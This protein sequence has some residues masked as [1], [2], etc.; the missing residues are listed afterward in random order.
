MLVDEAK[1]IGCGN[2]LDYCPMNA[3]ALEGDV[4]T[5]DQAECVECSACLRAECCPTNALYRPPLSYPRDLAWFFSDPESTHPTT[6]IPGRGTEEMKTNEITGRFP[7][8][9]A[10]IAIELGRPGTG[11]R[12]REVEKVARAVARFGV[13]FEPQNPVTALMTDKKAGLLPAELQ[14]LKVLSAIVEFGVE[15]SRVPAI[16]EDLKEIAPSLKTVFSLDLAVRC[17]ED[18]SSPVDKM[19]LPFPLSINGKTNTGLGRAAAT[20]KKQ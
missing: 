7:M 10:G 12:F 5:V 3:I 20:G 17:E 13:E 16:L 1:C 14:D 9:Y 11:T 18:G 4:A 8:G 6:E 19:L 2:C 15:L